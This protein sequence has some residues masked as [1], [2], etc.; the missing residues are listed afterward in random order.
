MTTL[1]ITEFPI[2]ELYLCARGFAQVYWTEEDFDSNSTTYSK[3]QEY[4]KIKDILLE[5]KDGD[6]NHFHSFNQI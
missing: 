4:F 5:P 6:F 1:F 2:A 3:L